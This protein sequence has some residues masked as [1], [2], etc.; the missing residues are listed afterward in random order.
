[1]G[2]PPCD[3]GTG[4]MGRRCRSQYGPNDNTAPAQPIEVL[5]EPHLVLQHWLRMDCRQLG[6][7]ACDEQLE[8]WWTMIFQRVLVVNQ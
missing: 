8:H 2:G 5:M 7:P 3:G 1:M 4:K 6:L